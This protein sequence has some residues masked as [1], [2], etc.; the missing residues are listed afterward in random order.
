MIKMKLGT[1]ITVMA[2]NLAL[3]AASETAKELHELLRKRW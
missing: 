1:C 2:A 3:S